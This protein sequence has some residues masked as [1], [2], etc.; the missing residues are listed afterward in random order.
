MVERVESGRGWLGGRV[1]ESSE[2]ESEDG[3]GGGGRGD[4]E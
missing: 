3:S 2:P 1:E 4:A